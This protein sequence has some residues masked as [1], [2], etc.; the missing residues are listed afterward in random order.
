V[1]RRWLKFSGVGAIG[2]VVQLAALTLFTKALGLNYLL[3]TALAVETAVLHNFVWH[4]RWT[5]RDRKTNGVWVKLIRFHLANG[6]VSIVSNVLLMRILTGVFGL[7]VLTANIVSI[8]VTSLVNFLLSDR[9]VFAS[10]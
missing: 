8:G 2:V 10:E 6:V 9:F 3:A 5:W 4:E 7:P 1:I